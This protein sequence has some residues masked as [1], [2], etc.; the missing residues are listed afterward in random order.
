MVKKYHQPEHEHITKAV[1]KLQQE[2][3]QLS[4][5]YN[6]LLFTIYLHIGCRQLRSEDYETLVYLQWH[7]LLRMC[8]LAL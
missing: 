6:A 4:F 3:R 2:V 7:Y 8:C 5:C 1:D